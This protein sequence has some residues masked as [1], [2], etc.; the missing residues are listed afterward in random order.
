MWV[1]LIIAAAAA[2][3]DHIMRHLKQRVA[4]CDQQASQLSLV[5]GTFMH[6]SLATF[7]V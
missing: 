2:A 5:P 7:A 4:R 3:A 6:F 1:A